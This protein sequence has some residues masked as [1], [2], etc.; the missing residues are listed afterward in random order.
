[1]SKTGY[2][3]VKSSSRDSCNESSGEK[4]LGNYKPVVVKHLCN[5]T[6]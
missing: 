2:M 6:V 1:M 4:V 5:T 3:H